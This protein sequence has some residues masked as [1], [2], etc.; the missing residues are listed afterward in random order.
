MP[1]VVASMY[2]VYHGPLGLQRIAQRVASYTAILV[3]GLAQ[4]GFVPTHAHAFD[5]ITIK[6]DGATQSIAARARARR[7]RPAAGP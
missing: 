1:A 3:R 2:A 7:G 5:T 6:T 4:L